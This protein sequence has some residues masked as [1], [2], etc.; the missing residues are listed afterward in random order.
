[1]DINYFVGPALLLA[2]KICSA[3]TAGIISINADREVN[4]FLPRRLTSDEHVVFQYPDERG[5]ARCCF[6][7]AGRHFVL[8][9]SEPHASDMLTAAPLARYRLGTPLKS[10]VGTP[11]FGIA[12]VGARMK[13]RQVADRSLVVRSAHHR[14]MIRSCTSEEGL[15][16]IDSEGTNVLS[17]LYFGFEYQLEHPTCT[18]RFVTVPIDHDKRQ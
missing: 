17:D 8:R 12:V 13:V 10:E 18:A 6:Q 2:A 14:I 3:A 11:F 9:E 16:V 15:H 1:M 4:L 5:M 7:S